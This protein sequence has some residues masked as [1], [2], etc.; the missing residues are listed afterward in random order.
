MRDTILVTL[1]GGAGALLRMRLGG[2]VE[3]FYGFGAFPF[4]TLCVNLLGC[5]LMGVLAAVLE[6][7]HAFGAELRVLLITG[8]L[9]GFTTFSAFGFETIYAFR[10]GA[11]LV[12][13]TNVL[14]SVLGGLLLVWV[15]L[16]VTEAILSP[17]P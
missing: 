1:G 4:G 5:L 10:R 6:K 15:G 13:V 2:L 12:A 3:R 7:T 16:R 11:T 9:G 14:V 8:L 17:T